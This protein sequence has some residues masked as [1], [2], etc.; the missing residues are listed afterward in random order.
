[1]VQNG[2]E[3][4][5]GVIARADEFIRMAQARG[6][7]FDQNLSGLWVFKLNFQYFQR[8]TYLQSDGCAFSHQMF[9]S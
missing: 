1:M 6:L 3:Q 2:G 4:S 9:L 8:L 7:D 5:F